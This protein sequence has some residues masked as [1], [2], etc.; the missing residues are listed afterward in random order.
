MIASMEML[1]NSISSFAFAVSGLAAGA[2]FIFFFAAAVSGA[3]GFGFSAAFCAKPAAG[4]K[5]MIAKTTKK[6]SR[7]DAKTPR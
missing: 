3:A 5:H 6:H 1:S 4:K 7:R 2:G